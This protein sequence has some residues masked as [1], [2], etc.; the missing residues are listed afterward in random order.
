[1]KAFIVRPEYTL[2][3][4]GTQLARSVDELLLALSSALALSPNGTATV[5]CIDVER[6]DTETLE[7]KAASA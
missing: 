4:A 1:M 6:Y 3:G 7:L 2:N 5:Q